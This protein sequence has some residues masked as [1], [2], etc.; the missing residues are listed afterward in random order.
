MLSLNHLDIRYGEKHLFKDLSIQVHDGNRI[1]LL[2]VNGAG[3]STLLK[4]MAG[5]SDC[6]DGV[7][8]RARHFTVAYLPQ[9]ASALV[10]GRSLYQEAEDAFAEL[11]LLQKEADS[12][13]EQLASV[14][15]ESGA[16]ARMLERQGE[17]QRDLHHEGQDREDPAGS[18][19]SAGGYAASGLLFFRR[20]DHASYACEN[21]AGSTFPSPA[22]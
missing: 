22:R 17:I 15:H 16:F 20:L 8:N 2:G 18:W 19:V 21:A 4:I 5:V 9:E 11:L 13:H 6:D 10:S 12:I 7:L 14:D 1:G 3:K